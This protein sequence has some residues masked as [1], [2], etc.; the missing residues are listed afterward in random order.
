M[1]V[2]HHSQ[3]SHKNWKHYLW[4]FLM[5][6][7]AVFC[8]FLAE[9]QLEHTIEHQREKKYAVSMIDDLVKDTIDLTSDIKWW[10]SQITRADT[11]LQELDKPQK[12]RNAV[13]LYRCLSLMRR[14]NGF[15]Y[16]DRTIDQLKNAG[17][18]RLFRK[19]DVAD[20][21]MEYDALVRRTLLRIEEGSDQIYYNLNFFQ[22]RIVDSRYYPT[23]IN[24]NG[25]NLD[26]LF[27][28]RPGAFYIK[29]KEKGD[30]FEYAN[31]LQYYKGNMAQRVRIMENLLHF[32]RAMINLARREYH[33]KT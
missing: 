1:E 17:F 28:V 11:I 18:F 32:A 29:E 20:S 2:H 5:L 10:R 12:A 8:G 24:S 31:H 13:V 33:L 3:G 22:N 19:K 4:E 9:Y 16:H 7:L 27:I 30:A 26:S 21:L 15:E 14:Y 23:I 6:F 25:F